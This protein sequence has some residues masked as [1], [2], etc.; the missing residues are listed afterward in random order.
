[1]APSRANVLESNE[2]TMARFLHGLNQD[3]QYMVELSQYLIMHDLVHQA[4][5]IEAQQRRHLA[6]RK[7]YPITSKKEKERP[8]RENS[9]KKGS[10]LTPVRKEEAKLPNPV[11]TSK[12]S[13]IKCFKC[14]H[15][16]HIALHRSNKR[17]MIVE[18]DG[19]MD[20]ASTKYETS[21]DAT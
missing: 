7:T 18:E 3:I 14:P 11:P 17:S 13:R 21:S 1:M 8:K 6:S 10:L 16:G 15:K 9:P 4:M 12:R 2:A 19:T 5:R 20:S